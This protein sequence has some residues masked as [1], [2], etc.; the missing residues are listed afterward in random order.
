MRRA[1]TLTLSILL[2]F[3]TSAY[4]TAFLYFDNMSDGS[5]TFGLNSVSATLPGYLYSDTSNQLPFRNETLEISTGPLLE[6]TVL[7]ESQTVYRYA[8]GRFELTAEWDEPDGSIGTGSFVFRTH[9]FTLPLEGED[10]EGDPDYPYSFSETGGRGHFDADLAR[11]LGVARRADADV[12]WILENISGDPT[13]PVRESFHPRYVVLS[14][15]LEEA[16]VHKPTLT[17]H[18]AAVPEPTVTALALMAAALTIAVRRR[19]KA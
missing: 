5:F 12:W 8:G 4:A 6:L 19:Q 14:I 2:W 16:K 13:S 11:H 10:I 18:D 17:V 9:G 15:A 7:N 3:P 1:S